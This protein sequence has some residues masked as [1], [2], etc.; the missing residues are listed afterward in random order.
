[1]NVP[2]HVFF[3]IVKPGKQRT[4]GV[5]SI[6]RRLEAVT[7][8]TQTGHGC[9][10]FFMFVDHAGDRL[11]QFPRR[12]A[13]AQGYDRGKE[14][15][16]LFHH[17]AGQ[18]RLQSGENVKHFHQRRRVTSMHLRHALR[19]GV[20][21]RQF[22]PQ[23][24]MMDFDNV[25]RQIMRRQFGRVL[26]RSRLV[27]KFGFQLLHHCVGGDTLAF[28]GFAQRAATLATEVDI[29]GLENAGATW[30]LSDQFADGALQKW[31]SYR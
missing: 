6:G 28:A 17:V 13:T 8:F 7:Q 14:N 25:S 12:L 31:S 18:L 2:M 29:E 5:A 21:P 22:A 9:A 19:H 24:T 30:A 11:V 27:S 15:L 4:V 1:M 3:K 26:S 20:Q 16:F 10:N 23:E